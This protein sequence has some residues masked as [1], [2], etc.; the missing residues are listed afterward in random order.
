MLKTLTVRTLVFPLWRL[1]VKLRGAPEQMQAGL[2]H[3]GASI[4]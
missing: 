3:L 4:H 2:E 1:Q